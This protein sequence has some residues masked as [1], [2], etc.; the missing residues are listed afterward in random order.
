MDF[1]LCV[2]GCGG[3]TQM[4]M[5]EFLDLPEKVNLF[6]ASRDL[7]KS[8]EYAQKYKA[9][10]YFGDYEHAARDPRVNAMY[11]ITPHDVHL[12]NVKLA[13]K[14]KKDILLEKPIAR[15][16]K[17]GRQIL[18]ITKDNNIC[19]LYTSPSQRDATLSRM[20]SSA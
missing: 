11:F 1:G 6:F 19:L 14:Y 16:L 3:Y 20:P 7:Q 15:T 12:E 9:T 13:T 17:E 18:K 2:V 4:V 5:E 10:D 8:K